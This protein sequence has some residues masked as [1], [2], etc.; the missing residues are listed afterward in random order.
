[1]SGAPAAFIVGQNIEESPFAGLQPGPCPLLPPPG[2]FTRP[3]I[4][5]EA[6]GTGLEVAVVVGRAAAGLAWMLE[7]QVERQ[8]AV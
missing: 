1:M 5:G 4:I 6:D 7:R 3:L 2:H 8:L